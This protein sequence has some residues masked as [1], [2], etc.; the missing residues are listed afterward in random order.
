MMADNQKE[1]LFTIL[2]S[3]KSVGPL[4]ENCIDTYEDAVENIVTKIASVPDTTQLMLNFMGNIAY[5]IRHLSRS[6]SARI[7][8]DIEKA[9]WEAG[10]AFR[11]LFIEFNINGDFEDL[12]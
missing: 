3:F 4:L 7:L 12:P 10:M 8:G 5:I 2:D 9:G 11:Y 1:G 6:D